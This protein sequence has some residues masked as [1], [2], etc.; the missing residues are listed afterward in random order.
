MNNLSSP[1]DVLLMAITSAYF[2][3]DM[4][5]A[6]VLGLLA[7]TVIRRLRP[8][9]WGITL[10]AAIAWCILLILRHAIRFGIQWLPS[11]LF[12]ES[13]GY[14]GPA[15]LQSGTGVLFNALRVLV[16]AIAIVAVVRA[17]PAEIA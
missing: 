5:F 6:I 15:Y 3:V 8:S 11:D 12:T 13:L 10:A 14:L 17:A 7:V 16:I 9:A 4:L 2:M 1:P